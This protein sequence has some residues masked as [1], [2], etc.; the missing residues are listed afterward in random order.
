MT[1]KKTQ[2]AAFILGKRPEFLLSTV[3]FPLPDGTEA[4]VEVKFTY[5]TRTEFGAL[6]DEVA[7]S[8]QTL[9][10][11]VE[12]EAVTYA[13]LMGK[14]NAANAKNTM[15]FLAS[16]EGV[17]VDLNEANLE[18]LFDEAPAA[19]PAFWEAYRSAVLSGRLGN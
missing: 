4:A 8:G 7:A 5:R 14:G 2:P 1:T 13:G 19:S 17:P 15:Q 18:Q 9:A 3:K 16:W 12:G 10:A 11:P 6:W